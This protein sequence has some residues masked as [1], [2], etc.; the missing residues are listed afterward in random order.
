[1]RSD[2]DLVVSASRRLEAVLAKRYGA[3]GR[4][5]HAQISSVEKQLPRDLV[6]ALRWVATMR[7]KVLHQ[8]GFKLKDRAAFRA[9]VARAERAL[10]GAPGWRK[11]LAVLGLLALVGWW[12]RA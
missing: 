5:L 7:N 8:D 2:I 3:T 11:A 1:M 4:G 9:E 6:H 12:L 10:G